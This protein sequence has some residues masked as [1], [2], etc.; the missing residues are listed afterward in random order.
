MGGVG[1]GAIDEVC[2]ELFGSV[3]LLPSVPAPSFLFPFPREHC[4]ELEADQI[5]CR[6][7]SA[8]E[9]AQGLNAALNLYSEAKAALGDIP[10]MHET[11]AM[12]A[13]VRCHVPHFLPRLIVPRSVDPR[14]LR[15]VCP[16]DVFACS[17]FDFAHRAG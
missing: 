11:Y 15:L 7:S 3:P 9:G 17:S 16:T 14:P 1:Y 13:L 5:P 4:D 8:E 6:S 10:W 12:G 2:I